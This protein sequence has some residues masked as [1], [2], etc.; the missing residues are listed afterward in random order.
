MRAQFSNAIL[1]LLKINRANKKLPI[2][3][4][5][6]VN[7]AMMQERETTPRQHVV[8]DDGIIAH[9]EALSAGEPR[10]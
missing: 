9:A 7:L 1:T 5:R 4:L 8:V 3:S 2:L 6:P 10:F